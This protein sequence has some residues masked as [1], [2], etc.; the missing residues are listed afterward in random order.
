MTSTRIDTKP[1]SINPY[2]LDRDD[3]LEEPPGTQA[4]AATVTSTELIGAAARLDSAAPQTVRVPSP[5]ARSRAR[6]TAL[7]A[8]RGQRARV[9]LSRARV[10]VVYDLALGLERGRPEDI[11]YL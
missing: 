9:N 8:G 1:S 5:R 3:E 11:L 10:L 4:L 7:P 2:Q 6:S